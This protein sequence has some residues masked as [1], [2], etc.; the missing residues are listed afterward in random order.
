MLQQVKKRKERIYRGRN[1]EKAVLAI[2]MVSATC[3]LSA[4]T[5]QVS[6]QYYIKIRIKE[7]KNLLYL[8]ISS[9]ASAVQCAS[10]AGMAS[11]PK[12]PEISNDLG[13]QGSEQENLISY[14]LPPHASSVAFPCCVYSLLVH[15]RTSSIE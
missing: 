9:H 1:R 6:V 5:R 2:E 4:E 8:P 11:P 7:R 12:R 3:T 13:G 10:Q 14:S 15:I